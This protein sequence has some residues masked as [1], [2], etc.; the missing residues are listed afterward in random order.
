MKSKPILKIKMVD[1]WTGIQS[2][3]KE[4]YLSL[5]RSEYEVIEVT[6]SPDILLYSCFGDEHL[7]YENVPCLFI[8]GE[9]IVPDFNSCDYAISTLK[10]HYADKNLWV[11]E[12][13]WAERISKI[14]Q[15]SMD[16]CKRKFCSFIYSNDTAG[17]GARKRRDFCSLLMQ[18]YA[19]VDCPGKILHNLDTDEL[20]ARSDNADW[21]SSKI[22]FLSNYK[23]N[24]AFE[25]SNAPGY[26]TEKLVDCYMA[27]TIPIYWGSLGDVAPYPKESMI[28][29][30][31]YPNLEDL[32]ARVMEV[33]DNDEL[34]LSIL[35]ANPFIEEN[36]KNMVDFSARIKDFIKKVVNN[37]SSVRKTECTM[38][39]AQRC[40]SYKRF[41]N[42]L[43]IKIMIKL[44][45]A[46]KNLY[47]KG[48]SCARKM[49]FASKKPSE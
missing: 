44:E 39:D 35:A 31:D 9:N 17:E 34:Y 33:N 49:G 14:E 28:C 12:S 1:F 19:H 18:K 23:F 40:L 37:S 8:C 48:I 6:K 16:P 4:R 21:H 36:Q 24:I 13:F 2:Y 11:P 27:K 22:R 46:V 3:E 20:A 7:E 41:C 32:C 25:N 43:H 42:R 38:S 29:A 45:T 5:F 47:Y 15:N 26:I 10:I 30:N